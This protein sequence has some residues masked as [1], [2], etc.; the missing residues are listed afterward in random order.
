M[1]AVLID[2]ALAYYREPLRYR[3]LSDSR[4]PLPRGFD[5]LVPDFS[6][7]LSTRHIDET[8]AG[9]G[10][11]PEEILEAARFF[12][13]HVLLGPDS[14]HY[15]H[16][17]L[18]ADASTQRV[19]QH[20]QLLIRFF[21]PDAH[22]D[23]NDPDAYSTRLNAAYH[24]LRD[25]QAR[26]RYDEEQ[27]AAGQAVICDEDLW[28]FFKPSDIRASA[29]KHL[30]EKGSFR[31]RGRRWFSMAAVAL[32]VLSAAGSL[33]W[34]RSERQTPHLLLTHPGRLPQSPALPSFLG[35]AIEAPPGSS[36]IPGREQA[37]ER[38]GSEAETQGSMPP[39]LLEVSSSD[40]D[41]GAKDTA[42]TPS[43]VDSP[44]TVEAVREIGEPDRMAEV[45][46]TSLVT[47]QASSAVDPSASLALEIASA[48]ATLDTERAERRKEFE[49]ERQ[50]IAEERARLMTERDSM[51]RLKQAESEWTSPAASSTTTPETPPV[52]QEKSIVS[53]PPTIQADATLDKLLRAYRQGDL[54]RLVS[55]FTPRAQVND[56]S[57]STFIRADYGDLF[58]RVKYRRLSINGMHWQVRKD[59]TLAGDGRLSVSGKANDG[60]NWDHAS[61][62]IQLELVPWKGSYKIAKM[63]HK[64]D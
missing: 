24:I 42:A 34:I 12:L 58:G 57:G 53:P 1:A 33:L 54:D 25:E 44:E 10:T 17:G 46:A 22:S 47:A 8:A 43:V 56:G 16:L 26:A 9:L 27:A 64:L 45:G 38:P 62:S 48:L 14:S 18:C 36:V 39:R 2:I 52:S 40:A 15:R 21:H 59:G 50:T 31:V 61:G 60:E 6:A 20:Y 37:L 19:R 35:G 28:H 55:L 32:V 23:G 5:A 30:A 51:E 41:Q 63:L 3:R 11:T 49:R 29:E 13:R 7:A 4:C